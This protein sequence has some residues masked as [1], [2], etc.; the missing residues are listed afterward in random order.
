MRFKPALLSKAILAVS[1]AVVFTG[2][3]GSSSHG[4]DPAAAPA[5]VETPAAKTTLEGTAAG[6]APV[7][8]QVTVKDANGK[9]LT[10]NIESNGHYSIDV[11]GLTAP[12]LLR[13]VGTVG[14][15]NVYYVSA[16]T[17]ADVDGTIN[18]TPFTDLIV[19]NVAGQVASAYFE[20][21]NFAALT[22]DQLSAAKTT[23]TQRL[24]PLLTSL[25]LD[26]SFDLM[27]TAFSAD[28]TGFDAVMDMVK[29]AVDEETG[30]ALIRD[31]VNNTS[32]T[33]NLASRD[34]VTVIPVPAV[35][36]QTGLSEIEAIRA[37]L[38]SFYAQFAT[39][40]PDPEGSALRALFVD[41]D[42]FLEGGR[43]LDTFLEEL[44]TDPEI[45]GI[46][47]AD[48]GIAQRVDDNTVRVAITDSEGGV[49]ETFEWLMVKV[50]G[51]W[52]IAGNQ[53]PIDNHLKAVNARSL[54]DTFGTLSTGSSYRRYLELWVDNAPENINYVHV[55]GPGIDGEVVL[56]RSVQWQGFVIAQTDGETEPETGGTWL[57]ECSD[58][59][60]VN[61]PCIDY[62]AVGLNASYT[63]SVRD[64]NDAPIDGTDD[65]TL[66]LPAPPVSNAV[67]QTNAAKWFAGIASVTPPD[68]NQLSDGSTITVSLTMP[69]DS[70]YTFDYLT[71]HTQGITLD[72]D[73]LEN[74]G[75]SADLTWSGAAPVVSYPDMTPQI[76]VAVSGE[77][78]RRFVTLGRHNMP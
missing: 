44:T 27:R 55:S 3:G 51:V 33:D 67:A 47:F 37:R 68:Y 18:I 5:P 62:G 8:G 39:S 14:G 13:A 63:F 26:T 78:N 29:V 72:T 9:L 15:R 22:A 1:F 41:G 52:R 38:A 49:S 56:K 7:V 6:G 16:A 42:S 19:A 11:T 50:D 76:N 61:T 73:S 66:T 32:I 57:A 59:R 65:F 54:S 35:S 4:D 43:D 70:R 77:H 28:H 45:V 46:Q 12:F 58:P 23:L 69:T 25:G 10:T 36:L 40:L 64:E 71:Y 24:Q 31:L 75:V 53:L 2:C 34:D 30:V 60:P 48:V 74:D 17:E 20:S 21:P